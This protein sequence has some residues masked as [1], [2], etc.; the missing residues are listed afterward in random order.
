MSNAWSFN[1][2]SLE[3]RCIESLLVV[4]A[5]CVSLLSLIDAK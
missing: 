1:W 2:E 4:Y 3:A 5:L